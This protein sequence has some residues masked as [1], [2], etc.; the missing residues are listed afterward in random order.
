M[1]CC[2]LRV[3]HRDRKTGEIKLKVQTLDDLW[4][5][6]NII[7]A[8]DMVF[9]LTTR[10]EET[11]A[12][13]IRAERGEKKRMRLGIR[14]EKTEFH[15]FGDWLRVHGI[16]EEGKQDIGSYHTLNISVDDDLTVQKVWT[17]HQLD[18]L[19]QAEKATSRPL[20]TLLAI[21]DDEAVIAQL[22]EYG[23]KQVASIRS[24]R[25]GKFYS[26][27]EKKE[28]GFFDEIIQV[29]K[30]SSEG[31][32]LIILGPGF[33]KERVLAYGLDKYPDSFSN[34]QSVASGQ[35][36]MT[37]VQEV[38][39]KGIGS[40]LLED[41][42]VALETQ[43]VE[44]LLAE[45]AKDNLYAYGEDETRKAVDAGAVETLLVNSRAARERRFE[46]ILDMAERS[47]SRIVVISEVHDSGKTL[48]SLGGIGAILRY[49]M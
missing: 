7:E 6:Y 46:K 44:E 8:G 21:D 30:G 18:V 29:L 45:I 11:R 20:I 36:G 1:W 37:G 25:S 27:K 16:I 17:R 26:T 32:P 14:V 39:K 15:E 13:S 12:D 47:R 43:L 38:L 3:R 9:A 42:R 2:D 23:V 31:G 4:H 34:C 35:S 33:A 49:K 10:R 19:E 24:E 22:R 28:D 40:K 41:S 5:L 48:E